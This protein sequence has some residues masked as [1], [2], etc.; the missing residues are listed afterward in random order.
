M[1]KTPKKV[2]FTD[3]KVGDRVWSLTQGW[4]AVTAHPQHTPDVAKHGGES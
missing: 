4:G 2:T 1:S 3:A